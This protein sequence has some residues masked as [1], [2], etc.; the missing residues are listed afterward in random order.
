M[1]LLDFKHIGKQGRLIGIDWGARRTGVAISDENRSFVFVREPIVSKNANNFIEKDRI[2][3]CD[4]VNEIPILTIDNNKDEGYSIYDFIWKKPKELNISYKQKILAIEEFLNVECI[5]V[6]T[7]N[8]IIGEDSI[9]FDIEDFGV[10]SK[11]IPNDLFEKCHYSKVYKI[12]L[13][14]NHDKGNILKD[15]E[16][17]ICGHKLI[18]ILEEYNVNVETYSFLKNNCITT[19]KKALSE[20]GYKNYIKEADRELNIC[21]KRHPLSVLK[22]LK[23]MEFCRQ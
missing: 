1:V 16:I 9:T 10:L 22:R 14:T 13:A 8:K 15:Y 11:R 5:K 2:K 18:S 20:C 6:L 17:A 23:E 3:K 19:L 21:Q 12:N 4:F 7:Q